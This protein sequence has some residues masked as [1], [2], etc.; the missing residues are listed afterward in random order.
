M[1]KNVTDIAASVKARLVAQAKEHGEEAQSLLTRYASERFLYRLSQSKYKDKFLL[2]GASLFA[3]WFNEPH[4]PT[5]D[6]DLLGFG[7][8]DIPALE[9]TV[10]DICKINGTDGLQFMPDAVA[11]ERIRE[12][13]AYQG[14]RLTFLAMLGTAKIPIQVDVGFGDAVTPDAKEASLPTILDFPAPSLRVYPK[15][16]VV[17][18]KFEAMVR[19]GL[20]NSRM[21]DFWD[22]R[23]MIAEFEFDGKLLQEAIRATFKNRQTQFPITLSVALTDGFVENAMVA[24]RWSGFIN[25]NRMKNFSDL[26]EVIQSLRAFFTP[27]IEAEKDIEE[28]GLHWTAAS[29]WKE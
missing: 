13:T 28:F 1:A 4:R 15:E 27:I 6:I 5:K 29:G 20:V 11:G 12:E 24:G 23:Y 2:K 19:F 18:E 7:E 22:V 25:R 21:K 3:L 14:I 10:R 26:E 17:A 9:A 16:T 8:S